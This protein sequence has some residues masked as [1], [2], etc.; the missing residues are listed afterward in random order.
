MKQI[1][2][3]DK[4]SAHLSFESLGLLTRQLRSVAISTSNIGLIQEKTL[5]VVATNLNILNVVYWPKTSV[6]CPSFCLRHQPDAQGSSTTWRNNFQIF[7]WILGFYR[8]PDLNDCRSQIHHRNPQEGHAICAKIDNKLQSGSGMFPPAWVA[9]PLL[10]GLGR[11]LA[12]HDR[13]HHDQQQEGHRGHLSQVHSGS[14]M[15]SFSNTGQESTE[16]QFWLRQGSIFNVGIFT[17]SLFNEMKLP[18]SGGAHFF[19]LL[20]LDWMK[21][22]FW[23]SCKSSIAH[24]C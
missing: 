15:K 3:V 7:C 23:Q 18:L 8:P 5:L 12:F 20:N 17:L 2:Q 13:E 4:T 11:P 19:S 24:C 14:K 21:G 9:T 6:F 1:F 16:G 22:R 10:D